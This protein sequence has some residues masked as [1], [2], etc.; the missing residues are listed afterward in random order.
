M[1]SPDAVTSAIAFITVKDVNDSPPIF[2]HAEYSISIPENTPVGTPLPN[3]DM[4]VHD[5]DVVRICYKYVY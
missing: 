4:F 1:D 3:L 2:N 5:P